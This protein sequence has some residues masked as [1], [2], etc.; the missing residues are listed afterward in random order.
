MS[1]P[2]VFI[3]SSSEGREVANAVQRELGQDYAAKVWH[4]GV[5][6]LSHAFL[7]SLVNELIHTDFA[8]LILTPDDMLR[9]RSKQARVARD[10]VIFEL[11][12]FM[13]AIGRDRTFVLLEAG[14]RMHLPTD[15]SG[16]SAATFTLRKDED[17]FAFPYLMHATTSKLRSGR[18]S[19]NA[20]T[21]RSFNRSTAR[22][23]LT[24]GRNS[25]R[26]RRNGSH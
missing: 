21:F 10:N 12:L 19:N 17:I 25:S 13:G 3:G 15:L 2:K 6:Q 4:Q 22:N 7:E 8:V 24:W 16:I 18:R 14:T 26:L 9:S 1:R 5:F 11:G 20:G 23:Y